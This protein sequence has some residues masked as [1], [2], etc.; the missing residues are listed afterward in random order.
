LI[1]RISTRATRSRSASKSKHS[2]TQTCQGALAAK[3]RVS[4]NSVGNWERGTTR[5][6]AIR[7]ERLEKEGFSASADDH[8]VQPRGVEALVA[9]VPIRDER[10]EL[11]VADEAAV[12][13]AARALKRWREVSTWCDAYGRLDER[14]G[15]IK[16][17]ADYELWCERRLH[18]A[19][20][21]L[22]LSPTARAKLG[23]D[24]ARASQFDLARHWAEDGDAE[25][26][27]E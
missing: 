25:E 5:P 7:L 21:V 9:S 10:G 12:E 1:G 23:L 20:D 17:A 8:G 18:E 27:N 14:T 16:D 11:P 22:G 6:D 4:R 3:L 19:L 2:R 26:E 13:I 15:A 24:L